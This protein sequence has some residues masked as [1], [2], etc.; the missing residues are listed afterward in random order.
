M[1]LVAGNCGDAL[2]K[3]E[4]ALGL[5][6]FLNEHGLDDLRGLGLAEPALAQEFGSLVVNAGDD[7]LPCCPDAVDERHGR[8][9]GEPRE[10]GCRPM[11]EA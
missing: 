7:T 11:P 3:I 1:R 8:G 6:R 4:D 10:R 9:V 2:H 5:S